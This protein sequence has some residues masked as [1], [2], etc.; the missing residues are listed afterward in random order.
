MKVSVD[1]GI[2]DTD[3]ARRLVQYVERIER[4]EEERGSISEDIKAEF[5]A[6]KGDG[7]DPKVMKAVL[8]LRKRSSE[9]IEEEDALMDAYRAALGMV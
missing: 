1:N 8:K 2:L 7:F 4:M 9:D 6:A 3:S 5:S